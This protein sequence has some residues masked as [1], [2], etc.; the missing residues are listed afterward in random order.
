MIR[1][2]LMSDMARLVALAKQEHASSP[3]ASMPFDDAH[4]IRLMSHFMTTPGYTMLC[5]DGGY[6][7]GLLQHA[8]FSQQMLAMEYVCY[9]TDG[10]GLELIKAFEKW[11][12]AMGA[13]AIVIHDYHGGERLG[14]VLQRRAGYKP[15]GSALSKFTRSN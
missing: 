1:H 5:S 10:S 14:K 7:A 15:L 12:E 13:S 6:L 11:G 4:V 2:A 9:S 3:W 8:G